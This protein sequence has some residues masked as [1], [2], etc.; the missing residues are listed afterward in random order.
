M[1]EIQISIARIID[2]I[3]NR[4]V[5]RPLTQQYINQA[6]AELEDALSD[7]ERKYRCKVYVILKRFNELPAEE[8][9]RLIKKYKENKIQHYTI[10]DTPINPKYSIHIDLQVRRISG[11]NER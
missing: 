4:Y 7:V 6:R 2:P 1:N 5:S 8:Q 11:N 9:Q 10:K 3:L